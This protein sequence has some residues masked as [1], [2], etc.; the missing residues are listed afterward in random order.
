MRRSLT[1]GSFAHHFTLPSTHGTISLF[2]RVRADDIVLLVFRPK[3]S[4][5]V[6]TPQ[7]CDY[8]DNLSI[9]ESLGVDL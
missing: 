4:T 5:L 3:D 7:L 9:F 8:R 2:E 6:C 1:I